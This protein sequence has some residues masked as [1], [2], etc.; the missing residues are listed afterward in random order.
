MYIKPTVVLID[1]TEYWDSTLAEQAGKIYGVYLFDANKVVHCC[2]LTGSR[3]LEALDVAILNN[4]TCPE[5]VRD[6]IEEQWRLATEP[7]MY[8]HVYDVDRLKVFPQPTQRCK[9]DEYDEAWEGILEYYQCN[10]PYYALPEE[11]LQAA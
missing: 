8:V 5:P 10:S 7:V 9:A 4:E 3:E 11:S 1:E 6:E 2:E